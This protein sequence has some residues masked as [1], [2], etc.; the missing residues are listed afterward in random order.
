[1]KG[2]FMILLIIRNYWMRLI[3]KRRIMHNEEGGMHSFISLSLTPGWPHP[4]I[5]N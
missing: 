4:I 2:D 1:M 3:M 5:A